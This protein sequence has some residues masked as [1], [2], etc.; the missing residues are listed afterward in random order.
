MAISVI[1]LCSVLSGCATA[2]QY[3]DR[4]DTTSPRLLIYIASYLHYFS[5]A[6]ADGGRAYHDFADARDSKEILYTKQLV[7]AFIDKVIMDKPD[8]LI[9]C[10]DLTLNGEK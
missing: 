6:L 4:S 8:A 2:P 1:S 7:D 10:G 5:L 3:N 9:L